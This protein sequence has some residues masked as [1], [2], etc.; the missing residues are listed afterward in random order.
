MMRSSMKVIHDGDV[1]A[2]TA[3]LAAVTAERDALRSG[4]R[5]RAA[6]LDAALAMLAKQRINAS[7][8][9]HNKRSHAG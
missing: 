3:Q 7:A 6:E 9:G 2:L 5:L 4:L 1:E 8:A